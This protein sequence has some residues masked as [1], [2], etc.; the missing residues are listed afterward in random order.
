MTWGDYRNMSMQPSVEDII[1]GYLSEH[2][3]WIKREML[4][5]VVMCKTGMSSIEVSSNI[6]HP[7]STLVRKGAIKCISPGFYAA[8]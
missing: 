8:T 6:S 7:L 5:H 3:G 2:K 1:V 4:T